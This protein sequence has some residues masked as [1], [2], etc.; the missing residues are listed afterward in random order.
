MLEKISKRTLNR[1]IDSIIMIMSL[2]DVP[3]IPLRKV[4]EKTYE[5]GYKNGQLETAFKIIGKEDKI[6]IRR[7]KCPK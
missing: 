2:F 3:T 7:T 5:L 6:K 1:R 4:I